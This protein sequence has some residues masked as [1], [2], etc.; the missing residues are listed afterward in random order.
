[1]E[2]TAPAILLESLAVA[3]IV[4]IIVRAAVVRS[5]GVCEI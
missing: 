2:P 5:R 3:V 4:A 1:V